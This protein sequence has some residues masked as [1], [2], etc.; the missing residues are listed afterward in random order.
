M[1]GLNGMCAIITGSAQGMGKGIALGLARRGVNV[2]LCDLK[3][4][5]LQE[6]GD[7]IKTETGVHVL[8]RK[9]DISK[10]EEVENF[11]KEA[12]TEFGRIDILVNNAGIHP[13]KPIEQISSE[14]WDLVFAVNVKSDF[15]FAKAV[16]PGMRKRKFGRIICISSEAGKNGG[17]VAALHYAASKG[18]VLG[19]VRNLAQQVGADGITV[20][21][22]AP[23]R[24]MTA[25]SGA[26]SPKENRK[27]ID[28][29]ITKSLGK[30]EDIAYAVCYLASREASFV[31]AE[32][33]AVNGG[34]LR[35]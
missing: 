9:V 7:Q 27:F 26:V 18:A 35:D 10:Q 23:G 6:T 11:V 4:A 8:C 3:W 1:E 21:A 34:T 5:E 22:I 33:M 20:N 31:T 16:L 29:S 28:M 30:P 15:F 19:F 12:E 14:E 24:I 25:M 32:T 13:L 2:A 17:T